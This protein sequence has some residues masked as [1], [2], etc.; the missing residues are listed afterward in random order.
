MA[1]LSRERAPA[2]CRILLIPGSL[3]AGSSNIAALRTAQVE[4]P[5][6]V[7]AHL[8]QRLGDL[9]HFNPDVEQRALPEPVIDLRAQL[10]LADAVP[11]TPTRCCGSCSAT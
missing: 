9:P 1:D 3:R 8:Y 11:S 10:N 6:G 7:H 4:A 5:R 2:S